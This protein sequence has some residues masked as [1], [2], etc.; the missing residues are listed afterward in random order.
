MNTQEKSSSSILFLYIISVF[1]LLSSLPSLSISIESRH[2]RLHLYL[3]KTERSDIGII[4]DS[5]DISQKAIRPLNLLYFLRVKSLVED[6]L[7]GLFE[8]VHRPPE[9][10]ETPRP[11]VAH[12]V[13]L[14]I[15]FRE[16]TEF[17]PILHALA[18][19]IALA[20]FLRPDGADQ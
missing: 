14:G 4:T 16:K 11:Q 13:L 9:H 18:K 5:K 10:P 2:D 6:H 1:F 3:N 19:V 8:K 15:P 7:V 20:P 17:I 12:K